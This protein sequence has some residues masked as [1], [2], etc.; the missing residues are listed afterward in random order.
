[1]EIPEKFLNF[2]FL[3][4]EIDM[5][6]QTHKTYS[7]YVLKTTYEFDMTI[8]MDPNEKMKLK[9]EVVPQKMKELNE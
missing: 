6:R 5:T 7:L 3:K 4:I 8:D 1:M 2:Y 9:N